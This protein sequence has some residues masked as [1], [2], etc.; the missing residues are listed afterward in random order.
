[1]KKLTVVVLSLG[2]AFLV[3]GLAQAEV[4]FEA[5]HGFNHFNDSRWSGTN[6]HFGFGWDV[7]GDVRAGFF[8]E[9][10]LWNW[11]GDVGAAAPGNFANT[12]VNINA[13]Q[14]LKSFNKFL[15][16]GLNLGTAQITVRAQNGLAGSGVALNQT[17]PF[18]DIVGR[19]QFL[20]A[21]GRGISSGISLDVGYRFLDLN[22]FNPAI[23]GEATLDDLTALFISIGVNFSF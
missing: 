17:K 14:V 16:A 2:L 5:A 7:G 22:D 8:F 1:V 9:E 18:V 10:G 13:I 3:A 15:G 12:S 19:A 4:A 6:R 23:A 11:R 20:A 21:S